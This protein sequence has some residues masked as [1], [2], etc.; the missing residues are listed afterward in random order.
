MMLGLYTVILIWKGQLVSQLSA[1]FV[2]GQKE[3][4]PVQKE[5]WRL[6]GASSLPTILASNDNKITTT[7]ALKCSSL[8][9]MSYKTNF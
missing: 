3:L 4:L 5:E 9:S 7:A 1:V 8:S 2:P 6:C